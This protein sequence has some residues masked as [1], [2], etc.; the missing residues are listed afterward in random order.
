MSGGAP[1]SPAGE[2][3]GARVVVAC[4][5]NA[6]VGDDAIGCVVHDHLAA[7]PLPPGVR[8]QLLG[9]AGLRLLDDLCGEDALVAGAAV[10]LGAAPGTVHGIP[11]DDLPPSR[12]AVTSHGLG[13]RE[14]ME[15]G[16]RLF[17]ERTPRQAFLVGVEGRSFDR[18]GEAMTPAVAAAAAPAAAQV[19]A[20]ARRLGE[21][22]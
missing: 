21:S 3:G 14:V 18:L 1:P 6:L 22:R 12:G 13:L 9:V 8:L 19:L 11:W 20:L 17:P 4:V 7:Q 10:A 5:G 2:R 16:Q 15:L